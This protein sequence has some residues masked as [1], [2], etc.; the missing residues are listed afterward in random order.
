MQ[1]YISK[2]IYRQKCISST[3]YT[4]VYMLHRMISSIIVYCFFTLQVTFPAAESVVFPRGCRTYECLTGEVL[5]YLHGWGGT[6]KRD[7][8]GGKHK[9]TVINS[10]D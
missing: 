10:C 3:C 2:N 8:L 6:K 1:K 4:N 7:E 9:E 5:L